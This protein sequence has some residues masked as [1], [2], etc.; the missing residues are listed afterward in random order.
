MSKIHEYFNKTYEQNNKVDN[1]QSSCTSDNKQSSCTGDNK[2]SSSTSDNKRSSS[3]SDKYEKIALKFPHSPHILI[4]MSKLDHISI[5]M[6]HILKSVESEKFKSMKSDTK[7]YDTLWLLMDILEQNKIGKIDKKD[8]F[9]N[10]KKYT[11]NSSS[12]IQ[13]GRYEFTLP[14]KN[15]VFDIKGYKMGEVKIE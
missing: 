1:K 3:T 2:R 4:D 12:L 14:E 8:L 11:K 10:V 7:E 9:K 6:T 5:P 13:F 15:Y